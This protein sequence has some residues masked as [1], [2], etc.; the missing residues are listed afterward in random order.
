M[1]YYLLHL[2]QLFIYFGV[3]FRFYGQLCLPLRHSLVIFIPANGNQQ[4]YDLIY[5][6]VP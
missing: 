3:K 6:S 4:Y 5:P 2:V 1:M